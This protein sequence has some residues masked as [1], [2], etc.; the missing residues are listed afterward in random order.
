MVACAT[1]NYEIAH[2][3]LTR[4]GRRADVNC[5]DHRGGTALFYAAQF[6]KTECARLLLEHGALPHL[7][8]DERD[9]PLYIAAL[10]G[11]HEIVKLLLDAGE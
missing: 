5:I 11:A 10:Q 7:A 1:G 2:L 6:G 4:S 9:C 8:R 3:L